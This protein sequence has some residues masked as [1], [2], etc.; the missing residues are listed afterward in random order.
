MAKDELK[1]LGYFDSQTKKKLVQVW[2]QYQTDKTAT[3]PIQREILLHEQILT[4]FVS[5]SFLYF[6]GETPPFFSYLEMDLSSLSLEKHP[7]SPP[8][9]H[10]YLEVAHYLLSSLSCLEMIH[11]LLSSLSYLEMQF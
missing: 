7:L 10:S 5:F 1:N 6:V 11:Y 2:E 3:S 4:I 9:S 8:S